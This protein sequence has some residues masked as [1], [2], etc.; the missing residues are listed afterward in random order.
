MSSG[1]FEEFRRHSRELAVHT[2]WVAS[3][4]F[5]RMFSF[6]FFA[7]NIRIAAAVLALLCMGAATMAIRSET[8]QWGW[9]KGL[10]NAKEMRELGGFKLL[11]M[12]S[13]PGLPEVRLR[14]SKFVSGFTARLLWASGL[15]HLVRWAVDGMPM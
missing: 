2:I 5:L 13:M 4:L 7:A 6:F 1:E 10:K 11:E 8:W 15:W 3:A 14:W 12:S 9:L